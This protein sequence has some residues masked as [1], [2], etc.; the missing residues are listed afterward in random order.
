MDFIK[1]MTFSPGRLAGAGA[2]LGLVALATFG[3]ADW[4]C[5]AA[6]VFLAALLFALLMLAIVHAPGA[7]R[8]FAI[9]AIAPAAALVVT[10]RAMLF[11]AGSLAESLES[12]ARERYLV[13]AAW[14]LAALVGASCAGLMSLW[15]LERRAAAPGRRRPQFGLRA[16]FV[17]IAIVAAWAANYRVQAMRANAEQEAIYAI[18]REGANVV[19]DRRGA[20]P[21]WCR[22]LLGPSFHNTAYGVELPADRINEKTMKRLEQISHLDCLTIAD[23]AISD[24]QAF[25][26]AERFPS[27]RE[28]LANGIGPRASVR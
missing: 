20:Y 22:Y 18:S 1:K 12:V 19:A 9:G 5:G 17:L 25:E 8:T 14:L 26:L 7:G 10:L 6:L 11:E 15:S 24:V 28:A 16:L 4:S 2:L 13:G 21:S 23:P 27:L 3:E